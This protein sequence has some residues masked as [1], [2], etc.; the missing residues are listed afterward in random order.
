MVKNGECQPIGHCYDYYAV[1]NPI[2]KR[3]DD[4][5]PK[6]FMISEYEDSPSWAIFILRNHEIW[7]DVADRVT[8]PITWSH[9][10]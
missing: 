7:Q 2:I 8:C 6:D 5:V 9:A 10:C 4:Q 1:H 3:F